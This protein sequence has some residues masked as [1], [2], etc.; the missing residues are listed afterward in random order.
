VLAGPRGPTPRERIAE[1]RHNLRAATLIALAAVAVAG[2]AAVAG[3]GA[4]GG[5]A[6]RAGAPAPLRC[7]SLA[8]VLHDPRFARAAFDRTIACNR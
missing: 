6:H 2:F 1:L 5:T 4:G 8:I 7:L 3:L